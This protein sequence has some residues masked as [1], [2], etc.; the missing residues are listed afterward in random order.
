MG[1]KKLS[2]LVVVLLALI[3]QGSNPKD[4]KDL[5]KRIEKELF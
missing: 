2:K 1:Y 3:K 4:H 5:L